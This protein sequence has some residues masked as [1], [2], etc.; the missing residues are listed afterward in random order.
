VEYPVYSNNAASSRIAGVEK[1]W[2]AGL[3]FPPLQGWEGHVNPRYHVFLQSDIHDNSTRVYLT[4]NQDQHHV[5]SL[6]LMETADY[7]LV[8]HLRQPQEEYTSY[9]L[10]GLNNQPAERRDLDQLSKTSMTTAEMQYPF[11]TSIPSPDGDIIVGIARETNY[12]YNEDNIYVTMFRAIFV[13]AI[14]LETMSSTEMFTMDNAINPYWFWRRNTSPESAEFVIWDSNV[15]PT[16]ELSIHALDGT[17]IRRFGGDIS[18][19]GD[20]CGHPSQTTSGDMDETRTYYLFVD[21]DTNAIEERL[22]AEDD[23]R[24]C[25]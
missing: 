8:N 10:T 5:V 18:T 17:I 19:T 15:E 21:L 6:Y 1:Q 14:T 7:V 9:V 4:E 3:M 24:V 2:S 25:S 13:D 16:K 23:M 20:A 22:V 11:V 12:E